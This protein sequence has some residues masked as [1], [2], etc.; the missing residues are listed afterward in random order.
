MTKPLCTKAI[1][2]VAGFGTRRL[3]IT[4]A[5]EKCMIPV[6]NRP[7]I[8]YVVQDCIAA[9][10]TDIIFVVGEDFEQLKRYYSR[11]LPLEE[12]LEQK[13][14]T[15]ELEAVRALGTGVR[16]HYVVQ[17]AY[18]AYGTSVPVHLARGIIEAGERFVVVLGDQFI[19]RTDGSSELGSFMQR[20]AAL[21]TQSAMLAVEVPL[22]ETPNYGVIATISD[23]QHSDSMLYDHIVERPAS[24]AE[25]PSNLINPS[26]YILEYKAL[27]F[28]T[29][30]TEAD[31]EGEHQLVDALNDYVAAGNAIA[32]L[33]TEGEY[34]DCGTVRGWLNANN[35]ILAI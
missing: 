5:I 26:V 16:F 13:G 28:I 24:P 21:K 11:N 32:V 25:A 3:P 23:P 22:I 33:K 29:A 1:I 6:G 10:I 4:K 34:L 35:R 30:N 12:Y 31:M 15:A 27:Q 20:T 14:K 9:G 7:I 2:P 8:D 17:D 18:Q 19:Y